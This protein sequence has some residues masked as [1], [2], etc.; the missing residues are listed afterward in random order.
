MN[1][2]NFVAQLECNDSLISS[3]L[4]TPDK[5]QPLND[6]GISDLCCPV[7]NSCVIVGNEKLPV[8][9]NA[10]VFPIV[11]SPTVCQGS[12]SVE[13]PI[14]SGIVITCLP[15]VDVCRDPETGVV[16]QSLTSSRVDL[17]VCGESRSRLIDSEVSRSNVNAIVKVAKVTECLSKWKSEMKGDL[18][19]TY[20]LD[21]IENGFSIVD[22]VSPPKSTYMKNY[23]S[24]LLNK[25]KVEMRLLEEI[26]AGNY[27]RTIIKPVVVSAL[28]AIPKGLDDVRLIH[29][30]SRP[31]GGVNKLAWDTSVCYTTVDEVTNH[32]G[33]DSYLAKV[34]LSNAYRSIPI[35]NGCYDLTGL[36]WLFEGD[37]EVTWLFDARLPFGASKSCKVFQCI[38][39]SICRM[40][41]R[42]GYQTF[43]YID[44]II[45]VGDSKLSCTS[46]FDTLVELLRELGLIVNWK[47]VS[48]PV[49]KMTFLGVHIDCEQRTL[50][51][52]AKK[53]SELLVL[54]QSWDGRRRVTKVEAQRVVGKLNW[55]ARVI[56]GGRTFL[57]SL[58]DLSLKLREP[59]HRVRVS[60]AARA[61]LSWWKEALPLFNGTCLFRCDIPPPCCAFA[62][63]AC[64]SGGG[65]FLLNDWFYSSW[66]VDYPEMLNEHINTLELFTVVLALRRWGSELRDKHVKVW[67]DNTC[68]IA[69]LRKQTSRG[70]DLMPLIREIYLLCVQFNLTISCAHIA[71][72]RN[73][74]AD[75]ISRLA[76][77]R[78]AFDARLLL[79]NF[80]AGIVFCKHHLSDRAYWFLQGAWTPISRDFAERLRCLSG[81]R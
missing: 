46:C 47:K 35:M 67:T 2:R 81:L 45:C 78:E 75:R 26:A 69:A 37:S 5:L 32:I 12:P 34:D 53:V 29:D 22:G 13:V 9:C 42:R 31:D 73:I 36:S 51:L 62:T 52:P 23:R 80:T 14:S 72:R 56:R 76:S 30:L 43:A 44:D 24:T 59:H 50:G 6:S 65:G 48:A 3:N 66:H 60:A 57:R 58:I 33:S 8:D 64:E 11:A 68:V 41:G 27:V 20:V 15:V 77:V 49:R 39:D 40:M 7:S 28:G 70:K 10:I 74:L 71:G 19:E 17:T 54:V 21:G 38:T 16:S 1:T 55:A 79:S 63:D 4:G 18:F 61:D 25:S